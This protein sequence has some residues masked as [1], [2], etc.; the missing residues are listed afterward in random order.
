MKLD[1]NILKDSEDFFLNDLLVQ[2]NFELE[3]I[4]NKD[5][6]EN[7]FDGCE[8]LTE[9]FP[10]IRKGF[11]HSIKHFIFTTALK[12]YSK[13]I[14]K[15]LT[16][17]TILG[18]A[19]LKGVK[20]AIVTCNH[21]SKVDSFAVR[22]A[23]GYN[24]NYVAADFNNWKGLMG[25]IGRNTGFLPLPSDLNKNLMRKFNQSIEY[26]LKKG[27]KILIYPEQAMWREYKK[28]RPM[29]N[30]AFHYAVKHNVP[31]LPLFITIK[32][33]AD[34]LD[35]QG[36]KNFGDYTIHILPAI[37]PK[38]DLSNKENVDYLRQTNYHLWKEKYEAIY[39]IPLEYITRD[40][41]RI[42]I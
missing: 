9:N 7:S 23:V 39:K 31:I 29:K 30:G 6:E 24:I 4:F 32:D 28:P 25:D 8:P 10:Y 42:K 16:N 3:G 14:N 35:E 34:S 17:L 26:Y 1:I 13:K 18:K 2:K 40:K 5:T 37:Y 15:E 41:S 19:N 36:R 11:K 33:K 12:A 20:G 38:H 21:V 22:A 27:R